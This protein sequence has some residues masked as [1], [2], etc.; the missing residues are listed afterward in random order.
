MNNLTP[1]VSAF[2]VELL[3]CIFG[4][5]L[6]DTANT[7]KTIE[8]LRLVN[9]HWNDAVLDDKNLGSKFT[10]DFKS[11]N[12]HSTKF[13][14]SIG[15]QLYH[16]VARHLKTM[17]A[18]DRPFSLTLRQPYN[19]T[20]EDLNYTVGDKEAFRE[21]FAIQ[22]WLGKDVVSQITDADLTLDSVQALNIF[23][24]FPIQLEERN[25]LDIWDRLTTLKLVTTQGQR[26]P[27]DLRDR[28]VN[29][30]QLVALMP[31]LVYM[32]LVVNAID[33]WIPWMPW[34]QLKALDLRIEE[35][36]VED[37]VKVL[38]SCAEKLETCS[39][40][41]GLF[42]Y[43][44]GD[45][46]TLSDP[47]KFPNLRKFDVH[48]HSQTSVAFPLTG[49]LDY[50]FSTVAF[51]AVEEI[52]I[53]SA[54]GGT[55]LCPIAFRGFMGRCQSLQTLEMAF[56]DFHAAPHVAFG[57]ALGILPHTLSSL[58]LSVSVENKEDVLV[59]P[60]LVWMRYAA[61]LRSASFLPRVTSLDVSI[62]GSPE[63]WKRWAVK[64]QELLE[65]WRRWSLE[66]YAGAPTTVSTTKYDVEKAWHDWIEHFPQ[67]LLEGYG[68]YDEEL[69]D[70]EE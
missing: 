18:G 24:V 46:S 64:V 30:G 66:R 57:S 50:L 1:P 59:L 17:P 70:E 69:E 61:G 55:R 45:Y 29:E 15:K 58:S 16:P 65:Q 54:K 36:P 28:V 19:D 35:S 27:M 8:N 31:H 44:D 47:V 67:D 42:M 53:R 52:H 32:K 33:V 23:V 14:F 49:P 48:A 21:I 68:N 63:D 9:R 62:L 25:P 56:L 2:P 13:G 20:L 4:Q 37:V 51:P 39:L 60:Q 40:R 7:P 43:F 26:M 5:A 11:S 12:W 38:H 10:L 3:S 34:K 41:V 22:G 6:A